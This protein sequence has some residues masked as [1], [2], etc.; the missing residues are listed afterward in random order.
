MKT[1]LNKHDEKRLAEALLPRAAG[2]GMDLLQAKGFIAHLHCHP[3]TLDPA[4]WSSAIAGVEP[5]K[6]FWPFEEEIMDLLFVLYNQIH[7]E[8]IGK[9]RLIP[10][11]MREHLNALGQREIHQPLRHWLAGQYTAFQFLSEAWQEMLTQEQYEELNSCADLL[12]FVATLGSDDPHAV[13][14]RQGGEPEPSMLIEAV[15]DA[16]NHLH[17][18]SATASDDKDTLH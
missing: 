9:Q 8:V 12:G 13:A 14:W 6:E 16:L 1:K 17:S 18:W 7:E 2:N 11:A 4:I 5:E 3:H 10:T 15:E